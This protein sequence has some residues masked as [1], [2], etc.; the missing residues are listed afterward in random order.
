M[1]RRDE[2]KQVATTFCMGSLRTRQTN[3]A[4]VNMNTPKEPYAPLDKKYL[5]EIEEARRRVEAMD[6]HDR[7][8]G[9]SPPCELPLAEELRT[10][11]SALSV[12]VSSLG[13]QLGSVCWTDM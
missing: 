9:E 13:T 7:G 5:P 3:E 10:C 4:S 12:A 6:A 8:R 1:A 11:L 2:R